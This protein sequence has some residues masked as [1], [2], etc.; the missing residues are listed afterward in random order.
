[1]A[2]FYNTP[3]NDNLIGTSTNDSLNGGL[4]NDTLNGGAGYDTANYG[5]L[6]QAI[7]LLPQGGLLKGTLGRDSM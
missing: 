6:S 3:Y 1:M 2:I 4:G 7:T 5:S